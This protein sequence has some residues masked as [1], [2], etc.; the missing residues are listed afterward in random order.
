MTP[1]IEI[2]VE[3]A[4]KGTVA[5]QHERFSFARRRMLTMRDNV[6]TWSEAPAGKTVNDVAGASFSGN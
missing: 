5:K 4:S 2:G 6:T 1:L 3:T